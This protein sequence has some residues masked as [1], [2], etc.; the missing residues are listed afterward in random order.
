M[1]VKEL[2]L[3]IG[4]LLDEKLA[5]DIEL[6]DIGEK[7]G[8]ADFLII[9]SAGSQ[10]Q[11]K[12]LADFVEDEFAKNDVEIK[13]IEGLNTLDWV[14]MDYGDIIVNIFTEDTRAKYS[15]EKIW[16]DCEALRMGE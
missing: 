2:A 13:N 4:K 5:K 7:S 10:R 11:V 3:S 12:A 6:I 15:L 14:L 9:C 8:F 16:G 1:E